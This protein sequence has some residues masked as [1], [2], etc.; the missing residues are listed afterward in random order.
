M[1]LPSS[2]IRVSIVG[3]GVAVALSTPI[4]SAHATPARLQA[5]Q[6]NTAFIDDSEVLIYPSYIESVGSN[7][8]LSYNNAGGADAGFSLSDNQLLWV[9]RGVPSSLAGGQGTSPWQVVYGVD[10]GDSGKLFRSSWQQGVFSVGGAWSR[11]DFTRNGDSF[12]V[13]G[14][15]RALGALDGEGPDTE[16]GVDGEL[17]SRSLSSASVKGWTGRISHDT[18]SEQSVVGG[19]Y[20]IGPRVQGGALR[21]ALTVEPGLF[22][23]KGTKDTSL[24]LQLPGLTMSSEVEVTEW[25]AVRAGAQS[26]WLLAVADASEFTKT[27]AWSTVQSAALGMGFKKA[28]VGR[29]DVSMDPMWLVNGPH[30]LSGVG[31][32]MFFQVSA[33]AV[34]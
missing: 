28:D 32:P 15:V 25:M 26:R 3:L 22:V 7:F 18:T 14:D 20:T 8:T 10:D 13:S 27:D 34:Y 24:L 5:L 29:L 31:T 9:S 2:S 33:Q 19:F 21:A 11:G 6:G 12:A 30:V 17:R 1:S 23:N 16:F 4:L